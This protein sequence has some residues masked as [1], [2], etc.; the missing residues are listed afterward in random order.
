VTIISDSMKVDDGFPCVTQNYLHSALQ[1]LERAQIQWC[2]KIFQNDSLKT[3]HLV[4]DYR[5][6]LVIWYTAYLAFDIL[7]SIM[8][9]WESG[10]ANPGSG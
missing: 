2:W 8:K 6:E 9:F 3:L 5:D 1:A 7:F 4:V 10:W